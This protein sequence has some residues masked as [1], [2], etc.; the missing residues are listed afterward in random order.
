MQISAFKSRAWLT[1]NSSET[2]HANTENVPQLF[3]LI[4]RDL[5]VSYVSKYSAPRSRILDI[6]ASTGMMSNILHDAGHEIVACDISPSM[7]EKIVEERGARRYELRQGYQLPAADGEFD[8][9]VSRMFMQHFPDW[10]V[11]LR[12]QARVTRSGGII[13]FDFANREHLEAAGKDSIGLDY[14]P[15]STE[16]TETNRY[17]A[18]ASESEMVAHADNCGLR[19]KE[20]IPFGFLLYNMFIWRGLDNRDK[21]AEFNGNLDKILEEPGAQELL[22]FIEKEAM[23]F[24]P[25]SFS[26]GNLTVL[27]KM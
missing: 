5:Y 6:G 9:V 3:N 2:Y 23:K 1:K 18:A 27:E 8:T 10:P 25:K 21:V 15:Y 7:L 17:Y 14:F 20:I 16:T 22:L 19:V 11:V 24:L 12:E 13:I 4:R 26:Y